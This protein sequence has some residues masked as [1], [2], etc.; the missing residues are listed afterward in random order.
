MEWERL[1]RASKIM[2]DEPVYIS[3]EQKGLNNDM[4]DTHFM[5]RFEGN[6]QTASLARLPMGSECNQPFL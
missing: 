1:G 2:F 6:I 5:C 4:E 3:Q